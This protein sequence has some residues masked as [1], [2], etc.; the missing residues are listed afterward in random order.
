[1]SNSGMGFIFG[2]QNHVTDTTYQS[3]FRNS[4]RFSLV[5]PHRSLKLKISKQETESNKSEITTQQATQ[6]ASAS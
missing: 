6:R 3:F 5:L 1:M 4:D 2:Q